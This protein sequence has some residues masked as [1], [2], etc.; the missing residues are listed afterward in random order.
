MKEN[1]IK[2]VVKPEV[3]DESKNISAN[4]EININNLCEN[5]GFI[6]LDEDDYKN[7]LSGA[8]QVYIGSGFASGKGKSRKAA[9]L[10][11]MNPL[12]AMPI[13]EA[14]KTLVIITVSLDCDLVDIEEAAKLITNAVHPEA[15]IIFGASFDDDME[16][17]I[18]VDIIASR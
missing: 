14:L 6:N 8:E 13:S 4:V 2:A 1:E 11:V 15:K 12:M 17:E 18:R 3:C 5:I 16:D 7:V 9:S 10:A